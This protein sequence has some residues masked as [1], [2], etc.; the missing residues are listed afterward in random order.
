[1]KLEASAIDRHDIEVTAW[2]RLGWIEIYIRNA[3]DVTVPL[4]RPGENL[5]L[6]I[7]PEK[8]EPM[9]DLEKRER[10]L[11]EANRETA[12]RYGIE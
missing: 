4:C 7:V 3:V 9:S 2:Q 5:V 8:R 10:I 6:L 1:M 12:R 11:R